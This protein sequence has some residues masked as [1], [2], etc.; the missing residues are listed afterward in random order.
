MHLKI[1][2]IDT[3]KYKNSNFNGIAFWNSKR[4]VGKPSWTLGNKMILDARHAQ[5]KR[6]SF[7]VETEGLDNYIKE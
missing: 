7:V 3:K 5:A 4:L 1:N 6:F 2:F